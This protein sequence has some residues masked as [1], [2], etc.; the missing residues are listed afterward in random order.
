MLDIAQKRS[1]TIFSV[2]ITTFRLVLLHQESWIEFFHLIFA[3]TF[4]KLFKERSDFLSSSRVNKISI[5]FCVVIFS[6]HGNILQINNIITLLV[7]STLREAL[8]GVVGRP[9]KAEKWQAKLLPHPLTVRSV[10][11]IHWPITVANETAARQ[12]SR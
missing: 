11:V 8:R 4:E 12:I 5:E 10:V 1:N 3:D 2:N 9:S 7:Q 6:L